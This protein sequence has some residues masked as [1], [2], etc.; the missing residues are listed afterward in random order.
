[1]KNQFIFWIIR[2]IFEKDEQILQEMQT[3]REYVNEGL[4][5]RAKKVWK[6]VGMAKCCAGKW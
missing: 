3:V 2:W 5:V 4:S 1:M 6:F